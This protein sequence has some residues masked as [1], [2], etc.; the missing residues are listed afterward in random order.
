MVTWRVARGEADAA[1]ARARRVVK[2]MLTENVGCVAWM[3]DEEFSAK[4][5]VA[6]FRL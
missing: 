3:D 6:M 5:D 1:V 4:I 2:N